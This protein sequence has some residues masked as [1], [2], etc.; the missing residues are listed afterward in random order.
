MDVAIKVDGLDSEDFVEAIHD[1]K[2]NQSLEL[3]TY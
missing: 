2:E 3:V 1:T